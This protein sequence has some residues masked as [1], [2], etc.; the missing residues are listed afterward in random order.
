MSDLT[1]RQDIKYHTQLEAMGNGQYEEV[2][3]AYKNDIESLPSADRPKNMIHIDDVYRLIAGHSDYHGDS[4]LSAFTCLV[5]GKD[6]KSIAPLDESA[7]RPTGWIPVSERLPGKNGCY[8]VSTTGENN[9]IIDIAYYIEGMWHKAS[10][11]KA[12]MPLPEPYRE[13]GEA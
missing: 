9:Y 6:V 1:S 11:I 8:L 3:V 7:D 4:I 2:E 12:W 13:D 10:R 5:E